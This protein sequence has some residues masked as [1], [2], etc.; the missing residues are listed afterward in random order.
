MT[1]LEVPTVAQA[2]NAFYAQ[3]DFGD[4]GGI[5]SDVAYVKIGPINFPIPN[6]QARK[7]AIWLHDLHHLLNGYNTDWPGEGR[8][9]AWELTAGGFGAKL[10]IWALVLAAMSVGMLFYPTATFRAFVRGT[11]CRPI[12]SL[13]LSKQDLMQL[14]VGELQARVGID[15]Q[16]TYPVQI[17]HYVRFGLL[18]LGY[19]GTLAGFIWGL[20]WLVK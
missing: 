10:Y 7:E 8:V 6:T 1:A 9:S 13:G 19:V 12:M 15:P 4:A 5:N 3:N 14:P 2:L 20:F 17:S 16:R 18:W 11:Y